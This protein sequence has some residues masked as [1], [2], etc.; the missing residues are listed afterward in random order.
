MYNRQ[1]KDD[2][3]FK[4]LVTIDITS[5]ER[6]NG[7]SLDQ[8]I[9]QQ[10]ESTSNIGGHTLTMDNYQFTVISGKF[11]FFCI[12][13]YHLGNIHIIVIFVDCVCQYYFYVFVKKNVFKDLY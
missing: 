1:A 8:L 5:N 10:I 13:K 4:L 3:V 12:R 7:N 2:A 11:L 9:R 6:I